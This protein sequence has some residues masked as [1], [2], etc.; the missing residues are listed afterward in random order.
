MSRSAPKQ[1]PRIPFLQF[2]TF[3]HLI[4]PSEEGSGHHLV[5]PFSPAG[6]LLIT[7]APLFRRARYVWRIA[8]EYVDGRRVENA[9]GI[10]WM[11]ELAERFEIHAFPRFVCRE[12]TPLHVGKSLTSLDRRVVIMAVILLF[13]PIKRS[14]SYFRPI[15]ATLLGDVTLCSN[16]TFQWKSLLK[17]PF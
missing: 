14:A 4:H 3:P 17:N 13:R 9:P 11:V 10:W 6:G 12:Y 1:S 15:C 5:C 16:D 8:H 2:G 7:L